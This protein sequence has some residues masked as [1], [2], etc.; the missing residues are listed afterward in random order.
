M[1]GATFFATIRI[2]KEFI[3]ML[4]YDLSNVEGPLYKKLYD[5]IKADIM[6]GALKSN[7]KMPSKRSLAKN[8]GVSTITVEN[9]YDQLIGEG[10]MYA[11]TKKGYYIA[12]ISDIRIVQA[13]VSRKLDIKLPKRTDENVFDFSSNRTEADNFPFSIW[14]KLMRETI[15]MHEK[16]IMV[17]S[18]CGGIWELREAIAMHLSSFRGMVVDPDQI[19][20]GAGTEY[21]YGLII[22]LLGKDSIYCVE[23]PGYRKISQ[24]Y[25]SNDVKCVPVKLDESGINIE[26]IQKSD[27]QIVHISP[28]HHFPTGI[29]MPINRRY[30]LLAWAN[31]R[32][33]RYIIEDDYDSEFRLNGKPISPLLSIDACEKVIYINTF[34]KSLTSTIRISY[35]VL[36]EHLANEFYRRLSFYSCTVSTFEQYT[37][38]Q[39]ISRGY[40][41]KHI[42]RMRLHYG[43]KRQRV[44]RII[45]DSLPKD[46]C[47]VIE[48]DSGLHFLL[49]LN[50]QLSDRK[51][52]QLLEEKGIKISAITDFNLGSEEENKHQF[53]VNY[54]SIDENRLGE[55]LL[56]IGAIL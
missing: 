11:I 53:I 42:N 44:L 17:V 49:E 19:I 36:P 40:F 9:A 20:V 23:D 14:A 28:T 51:V 25:A 7:E 24:I 50:T 33:D 46:K 8:L 18:P 5:F 48:N 13:P 29:T 27:A 52:E 37:L 41:E 15:S 4:T 21:L 35:M 32:D 10:Y 38:A 43:R 30:E 26:E 16:E 22:K 56:V 34:S 31:E 55:V 54:S 2:L 47:R 3:H 6:S 12:D 1:S 39:F 45:R